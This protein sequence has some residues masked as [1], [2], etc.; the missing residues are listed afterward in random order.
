VLPAHSPY[1]LL[2]AHQHGRKLR[3]AAYDDRLLGPARKRRFLADLLRR[4][5]DRLDPKPLGQPG[6]T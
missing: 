6:L 5:A 2:L 3:A 1:L 4:T